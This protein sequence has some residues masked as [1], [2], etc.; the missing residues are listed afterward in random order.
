MCEPV[1]TSEASSTSYP[2]ATNISFS[3]SAYEDRLILTP[4]LQQ[5]EP[6]QLLMTRRMLLL[7]LQQCLKH[8]PAVA[9]L[10]QTPAHYWQ[11][12]LQLN[13]QSAIQQ[14]GQ[15]QSTRDSVSHST[16]KTPENNTLDKDSAPRIYLATEIFVQ[17]RIEQKQCNLGFK[18]LKLPEAMTQPQP[19][20]PL[21]GL[22]LT[23][24]NLHQLIHQLV[25]Q[26]QT[27]QW[28]LPLDLPWLNTPA[29]QQS[30]PTS[31]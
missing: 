21:V 26:A 12:V 30:S 11:D 29:E 25:T 27:A 4:R 20:E 13:H 23:V 15:A 16:Q 10:N 14:Q 19:H 8:L 18:G 22:S 24:D 5:G 2:L 7:T 6:L 3:F 31:Q 28:H 9:G 17:P 1:S